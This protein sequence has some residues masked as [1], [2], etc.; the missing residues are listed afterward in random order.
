MRTTTCISLKRALDSVLSGIDKYLF[1]IASFSPL[2]VIMTAG[3]ALNHQTSQYLLPAIVIPSAVTAIATLLVVHKFRVL[4]RS[5]NAKEVEVE[6]VSEVTVKYIPY[7]MSYMFLIVVKIED[8]GTLVAVVASLTLIGTL[9]VKTRM[10]LINPALLLV[11]FRVYEMHA[12]SYARQMTIISKKLP[13]GTIK[14]RDIDRDL[15]IV[16]KGQND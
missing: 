8:L 9:Y 14:I 7:I 11:G 6:K 3:Y 16:Q 13:E 10:V 12:A 1:F 2:W 5:T 4:R 15:Y